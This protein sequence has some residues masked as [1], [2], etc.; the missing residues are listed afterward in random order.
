MINIPTVDIA[1]QVVA[2]GN[3]SG[4]KVDKFKKHHLT[5]EPG[6]H[7]DA[8]L[9]AECYANLECRVVDTRM[10]GNYCMFVRKVVSAWIDPRKKWP[11]TLPHMGKGE[12]MVAATMLKLRS[13]M[14]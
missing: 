8:P 12:F 5:A 6:E 1:K 7:L 4:R 10:V 9:F 11:R 14:K 13:K 3:A 2:R